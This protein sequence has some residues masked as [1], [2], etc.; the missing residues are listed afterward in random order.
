MSVTN[1]NR[2]FFAAAVIL[3]TVLMIFLLPAQKIAAAEE[4]PKPLYISEFRLGYGKTAEEAAQSL[5]GY[6][7]LKNGEKYANLNEGSGKK[8]VV[9]MGYKTTTNRE[10]AITDIAAMNMKGGYSFSDY[11]KLMEQY[12]DSQI[13]PFIRRF[14][15]TVNE[16]RANYNGTD[17][18]NKAKAQYV[19]EM[20]NLYIDDDTGMGLGD[21]FLKTTAEELGLDKYNKLSDSEKKK[22]GCLSTILM[23]AKTT[24]IFQIE[25]MLT[26]ASD[27]SDTTWLQ[28]FSKISADDLLKEYTDKG[29]GE[30][31]AKKALAR[32]YE[33]GAR[34]IADK[35]EYLRSYLIEYDDTLKEQDGGVIVDEDDK[36]VDVFGDIDPEE[37]DDEEE[38]EEEESEDV[39]S[40]QADSILDETDPD[41]LMA[42]SVVYSSYIE[43]I[44]AKAAVDSA[45][46]IKTTFIYNYLKMM[47]YGGKTM[48]DYFTQPYDEIKKD[49]YFALYPLVASLTK[50][51]IVGMEFLTL[52]Q[53]VAVGAT[54]NSVYEKM[55]ENAKPV[56]DN[57]E[58]LSVF[59]GVNREL[60]SDKVAL[61]DYALRCNSAG[62]GVNDDRLDK[63]TNRALFL[64]LGSLFVLGPTI[65]SIWSAVKAYKDTYPTSVYKFAQGQNADRELDVLKHFIDKNKIAT[66]K[67]NKVQNSKKIQDFIK[68]VENVKGHLDEKTQVLLMQYENIN[69]NYN[70]YH[71]IKY[72]FVPTEKG[73]KIC[74][75][76]DDEIK[77]VTFPNGIEVEGDDLDK[78]V[79]NL[80][81]Q[82]VATEVPAVGTK[83]N[84]VLKAGVATIF[85]LA[86][87]GLSIYDIY[88]TT[89]DLYN[90]YNVDMTLVPK[91][92]VERCDISYIDKNGNR[93]ICK[94]EEAYYQAIG[95][96]RSKD[97]KFYKTMQDYGDV[98]AAE[99]KQWL[100][101][102]TNKNTA[103][104]TPILAD[105]LKVVTG[106]SDKPEGY[107]TGIHM[108]GEATPVNM[109]DV[110]FTYDNKL[111]DIYVY[112]KHAPA[113]STSS[114]A[115]ANNSAGEAPATSSTFSTGNAITMAV[116]GLLVG[117]AVGVFVMAV[118]KR[119]N[120]SGT[121]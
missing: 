61:T 75:E 92:I 38:A 55:L 112:Y 48:Y 93:V 84:A 27:T 24:T 101:L 7:I 91:Y 15:E 106:T 98:N 96:N 94:N 18:N 105:S 90:Y 43:G 64:G 63:I 68:S 103:S 77:T 17:K 56:M 3:L 33:G 74:L 2:S 72:D 1:S 78:I 65:Q 46:D 20:L 83:W 30:T 34:V 35:W 76:F 89:V 5:A 73:T 16:Y 117:I 60:Y 108:F 66:D 4:Q 85:S 81:K 36:S 69:K 95:S 110:R 40:E 99:G 50:G 79:E 11:E 111:K 118:I 51:Q 37:E 86:F 102:Y 67:F 80:E 109:T 53:L 10:E 115:S 52:E 41:K 114:G 49:N 54:E 8:T 100:V 58:P 32:E 88:V 14:M 44:F 71:I 57:T 9:L 13:M 29:M 82:R 6:E 104:R 113:L 121:E 21:V 42:L 39:T 120:E 28:R 22:Y 25:Q 59:A 119:K 23:Q 62:I 97:H 87:L 116:C 70:K 19:R 47:E 26:L 12:R 31:D 107:T 45:D